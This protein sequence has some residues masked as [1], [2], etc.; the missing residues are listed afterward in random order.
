MEEAL[1]GVSLVLGAL[2]MPTSSSTLK[3]AVPEVLGV[4]LAS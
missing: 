2:H 4:P 1:G 3:S